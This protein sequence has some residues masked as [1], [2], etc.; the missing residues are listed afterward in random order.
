MGGHQVIKG[1]GDIELKTLEDLGIPSV[2]LVKIDVEGMEDEI[3]ENSTYL[4]G[5]RWIDVEFHCEPDAVRP[6]LEKH[7]P[8]FD[9]VL[10]PKRFWNRVWSLLT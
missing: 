10:Y 8:N 5:V 9:I 1:D 3:I 7:L 6:F 2:D 4:H